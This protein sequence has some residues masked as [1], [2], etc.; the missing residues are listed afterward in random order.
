VTG[1]SLFR[2]PS[3][4]SRILLPVEMVPMWAK[5]LR[6]RESAMLCPAT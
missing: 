1:R 6:F 3:S 5:M 4:F 2:F